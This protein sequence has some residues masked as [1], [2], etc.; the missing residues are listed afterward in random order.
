[1]EC[2]AADRY[3]HLTSMAHLAPKAELSIPVE[4]PSVHSQIPV[5]E[6]VH[7]CLNNQQSQSK[8]NHQNQTVLTKVQV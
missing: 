3:D 1:M 5:Q 8:S 2:T 4:Q 6:A 7:L